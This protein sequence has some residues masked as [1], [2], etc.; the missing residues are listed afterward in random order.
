MKLFS[1]K[2]KFCEN[3]HIYFGYNSRN[4]AFTNFYNLSFYW[5]FYVDV[6]NGKILWNLLIN[7]NITLNTKNTSKGLL[8]WR[9]ITSETV[10]GL[11]KNFE[12]FFSLNFAFLT[13]YGWF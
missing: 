13:Y 5:K 11:I 1:I 8:K 9:D 10:K 6:K 2:L 4:I 7:K 12:I 3:E